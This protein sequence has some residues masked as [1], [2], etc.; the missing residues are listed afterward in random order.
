MPRKG[1]EKIDAEN[2]GHPAQDKAKMQQPLI[3]R[4][5]RFLKQK[6][7]LIACDQG[8]LDFFSCIQVGCTK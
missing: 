7:P 3:G 6:Q 1:F 4:K 5:P 8:L 2:G